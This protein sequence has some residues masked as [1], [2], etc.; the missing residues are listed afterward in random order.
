MSKTKLL[1]AS[2]FLTASFANAST[3]VFDFE[4]AGKIT[5]TGA[6]TEY[7]G[8]DSNDFG[9]GVTTSAFTLTDGGANG[10]FLGVVGGA[11]TTKAH[12]ATRD[13]NNS[14]SFSL[15]IPNGVTVDLTNLSFQDGFNET[16][17]PNSLTPTWSLAISTG[18]AS[19][20]S[21]GLGAGTVNATGFFSQDETLTLSGLTGLTDTTVTFTWTYDSD[22]S[23]SL[24]RAHTI[25]NVTLTGTA[26]AVPEPS[27]SVLIGLGGL[28]LILRRRK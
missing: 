10:D 18:S 3:I 28:A 17:H 24:A 11:G 16:F 19:P 26:V 13:P 2:A 6:A 8:P 23:N 4:D 22:R 20:S 14:M 25:D 15:V 12:V 27:S 9:L 21:G 1:T 7:S 5:G